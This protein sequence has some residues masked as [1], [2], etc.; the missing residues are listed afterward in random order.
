MHVALERVLFRKLRK[1]ADVTRGSAG[2]GTAS[3]LIATINTNRLHL[4]DGTSNHYLTLWDF[5]LW[6][7][8]PYIG[9]TVRSGIILLLAPL[10][11]VSEELGLVELQPCGPSDTIR[12]TRDKFPMD[13]IFP[14]YA[15]LSYR[16]GAK[17]PQRAI[18]LNDFY[19]EI[20]HDLWT[21]LRWVYLQGQHKVFWIDAVCIN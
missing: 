10:S 2:A 3:S 13:I 16:W 11:L 9:R 18:K 4:T 8:V 19:F 14:P 12:C 5:G 20:G 15:A 1:M 17:T 6:I 7:I 21:F